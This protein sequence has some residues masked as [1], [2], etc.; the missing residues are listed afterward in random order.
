MNRIKDSID[1]SSYTQIMFYL[2]TSS[3]NLSQYV[4]FHIAER[5]C[6]AKNYG[7]F[8]LHLSLGL[9]YRCEAWVK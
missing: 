5:E 3:H 1:E 6:L 9:P 2:Y 4:L 7:Y 8:A